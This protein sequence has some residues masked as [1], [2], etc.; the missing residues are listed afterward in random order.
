[1][2]LYATDRV[3]RTTAKRD[4]LALRG[5][6]VRHRRAADGVAEPDHTRDRLPAVLAEPPVRAA[7]AR[8][9][10]C[11]AVRRAGVRA[12]EAV[13]REDGGRAVRVREREDVREGVGVRR[14]VAVEV[15]GVLWE[16]Q[17]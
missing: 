3:A 13:A 6:P 7:A 11:A 4:P 14:R 16:R 15:A 12:G 8:A 5:R 9:C 2:T 10:A 1:M 17:T